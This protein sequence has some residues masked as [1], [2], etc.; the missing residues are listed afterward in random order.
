M[1][2]WATT[3]LGSGLGGSLI[4]LWLTSLRDRRAVSRAA[5]RTFYV[6]LLTVF[7]GHR[8]FMK[9]A[10]FDPEAAPPDVP[11]DQIDGLNALLLIDASQEVVALAE[12]C[13]ELINRFGVSRGL[14]VPVEVDEHGLYRHRFD[15][16]RE[17]PEAA[18]A[19]VM[20][21][22]LGRISDDF[23]TRIVRLA[24]RVRKEIHP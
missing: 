8:E 17:Q 1:V 5:R 11:K 20:R 14:Q 10:I 19:I 13:F 9:Q 6:E 3:V 21:L 15:L 2:L 12:P 4:T 18:S 22:A 23:A 16:V 7:T 24:A